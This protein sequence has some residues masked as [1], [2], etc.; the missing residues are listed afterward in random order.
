M[1]KN[2]ALLLMAI[3]C[4]CMAWSA[5]AQETLL[6]NN[7]EAIAPASNYF[8]M[9]PYPKYGVFLN[10]GVTMPYTD[11]KKPTNT[12]YIIGIEG[13][14]K[15][16]YYL[17]LVLGL[18]TGKLSAGEADANPANAKPKFDNQIFN[19]IVAA[20][21]SPLKLVKDIKFNSALYY[22][23]NLY[24]GAG[25]GIV[26]SKV[27]ANIFPVANYKYIGNY[28]GMDAV[29]PVEAG[30]TLPVAQFRNQQQ[31]KLNLNYRV[32]FAMGDKLDGYITPNTVNFSNDAYNTLTIGV[33]YCF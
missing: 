27:E 8:K 28:S 24:V 22:F 4:S 5:F 7:P 3:C 32:N 19:A 15:V 21:F 30:I 29:I 31:L 6:D 9:N 23:G 2:F 1:K 18:Q 26:S 10:G 14:Y 12:G 16:L 20:R 13:Q 17:D 33:G 11:I 25:I